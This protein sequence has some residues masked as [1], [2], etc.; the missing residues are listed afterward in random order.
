MISNGTPRFAV[1][2][3]VFLILSLLPVLKVCAFLR[4]MTH[5]SCAQ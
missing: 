1:K 4:K 3:G 5:I 2:R